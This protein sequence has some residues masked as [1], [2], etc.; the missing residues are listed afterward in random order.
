MQYSSIIMHK[1]NEGNMP[2]TKKQEKLALLEAIKQLLIAGSASTQD[3]IVHA[4]KKQNYAVNQ[5]KISRLLHKIGAVKTMNDKQQIIY[6]LPRD[7]APPSTKSPLAHLIL[8]I[9]ANESLIIVRTS[10]G[11]A[12]LIGRLLDHHQRD[13]E[14]LGTIAGDDT[15]L[16]VPAS[17]KHIQKS[18]LAIKE[19]L[20]NYS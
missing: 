20:S 11:S 7:P 18:L 14:I 15:L 12:S 17:N 5:S 16:V 10:P 3:N 8:D 6:S 9:V 4:L 2:I 1:L 19:L 13:V